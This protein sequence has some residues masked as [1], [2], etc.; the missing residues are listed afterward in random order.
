MLCSEAACMNLVLP[1]T[2]NTSGVSA[3]SFAL[4]SDML[5]TLR[6]WQT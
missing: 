6:D 1:S 3:P 2:L 5:L 4:N